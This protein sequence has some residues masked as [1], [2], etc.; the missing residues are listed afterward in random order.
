MKISSVFLLFYLLL[1]CSGDIICDDNPEQ[2]VLQKNNVKIR[3]GFVYTPGKDSLS[4]LQSVE[5]FDERG[6]VKMFRHYRMNSVSRKKVY[7]YDEQGRQ[8][9]VK[10]SISGNYRI[11]EYGN[12]C[13]ATKSIQHS[14]RGEVIGFIEYKDSAGY[15][16]FNH[17]DADNV[18]QK[19]SINKLDQYGNPVVIE[20]YN[21]DY[22]YDENGL[23]VQEIRTYG[24]RTNTT[25]VVRDENDLILKRLF[26]LNGEEIGGIYYTY[27]YYK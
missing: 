8:I 25:R 15:R 27:E 10:D 21:F 20:G 23:L 26:Y 3:K 2:K 13:D 4:Q 5:Y 19:S 16:I 6:S 7:E 12:T 24:G 11:F 18:L 9:E 14:Y 1:G 17:Y 22:K